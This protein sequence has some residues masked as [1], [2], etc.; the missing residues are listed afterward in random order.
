MFAAGFRS[1]LERSYDDRAAYAAGAE[2]R[3]EGVSNRAAYAPAQFSDRLQDLTGVA[4]LT[5]ASRMTGSYQ[6]GQFQFS[7]F[8][9]LG[10][11]PDE[12]AD[13]VAWRGDYASSS[14]DSLMANLAAPPATINGPEIPPGE[15]FVGFWAR[16]QLGP[17][18]GVMGLRL[19]D[20]EG[21]F[22]EYRLAPLTDPDADGWR[23]WVTD[24]Q[25]PFPQRDGRTPD[26]S[27]PMYLNAIYLRMAG[28]PPTPQPVSLEVTDVVSSAE[29]PTEEGFASAT[30]IEVFD[31]V[32]GFTEISGVSRLFPPGTL[33]RTQVP[34]RS[35]ESAARVDTVFQQ[36][37]SPIFGLRA[38]TSYSIVPVLVSQTFLDDS[39]LSTGEQFQVFTNRQYVTL[40]VAGSFDYFPTWNPEGANH[41]FVANLDTLIDV[42][43]RVPALGEPVIANELWVS[44]IGGGR[45][46]AEELSDAGV[47]V[48]QVQVREEL[49]A[50]ASADPL[51]AASWEGILFLSFAAVLFL[52]ALGFV[53]YSYLTAQTRSLEFA[54]L[55]TMGFSG[56]QIL[57]LVS[58]E[59][60]FVIAAGVSV[61]TI[62]GNPLGRLMIG[63]MGIT[64]TGEDRS[65]RRSCQV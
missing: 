21:S 9:M 12:F 17:H 31:D 14:I 2:A 55:R 4:G 7:S 15:R 37:G 30:A 6:R 42:G 59:Q 61:G 65:F 60:C 5:P 51:V 24:T 35:T 16:T 57:G 62:L 18:N 10:V 28:V 47:P 8:V 33:S 41:L 58:F 44:D 48:G 29:P 49:R 56:K 13:A 22:W 38:V 25:Q 1:T 52:T 34:G 63:Y 45:I 11:Q 39:G 23:F 20:A 53:V 50:E 27:A 36:G 43:S 19:R 40:E 3:V 32:S 64:E 46:D 26:L 54:I